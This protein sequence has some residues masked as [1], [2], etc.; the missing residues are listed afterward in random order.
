MALACNSG[1]RSPV[2]ELIWLDEVL[3]RRDGAPESYLC[4][5]GAD[6]PNFMIPMAEPAVTSAALARYHDG[7]SVPERAGGVAAETAGRLGLGRWFPGDRLELGPW[8]LIDHLEQALGEPR[9]RVALTLGPPRRNRKPV[10]QLI[11]PDGATVGFAKVGWS[12]LTSEL[13]ANESH[14]LREIDGALPAGLRAPTLLHSSLWND[15]H[16]AVT[17]PLPTSAHSR[18]RQ[19]TPSILTALAR[20]RAG[21]RVQVGDLRLLEIWREDGLDTLV[22]LDGIV[23]RY[24][25]TEL[26]LGLWHGDLTPWNTASQGRKV[27]VWDWEFA[28]D[29][30]PVGFDL[31]HIRFEELRR[32]RGGSERSAIRR[33]GHEVPQIVDLDHRIADALLVLHRCDLLHRELRL[34]GQRWQPNDLGPLDRVLVE[35][36]DQQLTR[37][38]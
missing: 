1:A 14:W 32:R 36:I 22:D 9:L 35:E 25:E 23:E 37:A 10:L 38:R 11:R 17:G 19:L 26:E 7:R 15:Y 13:V 18:P 31:L 28:G 5:P 29:G 33:T 2:D 27:A 16:V 30:R 6:Q 8:A 12:A 24:G 20:V 21:G 3:G 4:R 34:A